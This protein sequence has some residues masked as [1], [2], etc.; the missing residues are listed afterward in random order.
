ML[1]DADDFVLVAESKPALRMAI[2]CFFYLVWSSTNLLNN[3][4][5]LI[6]VVLNNSK[7]CL[8][9]EGIIEERCE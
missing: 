3:L 6:Q 5:Y 7:G 4:T 9:R 1:V 8:E 2:E